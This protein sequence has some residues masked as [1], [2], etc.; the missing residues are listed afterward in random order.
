MSKSVHGK[1][2]VLVE[3]DGDEFH[4]FC[5]ALPGLHVGGYTKQE[6]LQ[7]VEDA[8]YVY[9]RSMID[10][11]EPLPT[12]SRDLQGPPCALRTER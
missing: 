1:V 4:A 5:P 7:N 8:V 6:L 12:T 3:P 11:E 9:L 10:H 2:A